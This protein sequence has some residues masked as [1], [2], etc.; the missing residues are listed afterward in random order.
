MPHIHTRPGQHDHTVTGYIV[1]TD[2]SEP[3]ALLHMHKKFDIL[4][5][6]GGHIELDENPWQAIC[7]EL[8][9]ESGY[10]ISQLRILQPPGMLQKLSGATIHPYPL[11]LNTHA[12]TPEHFHSDTAFG[13]IASKSPV[14]A[15]EDSESSDIR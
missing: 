1:R 2:G 9:E 7:H 6:V 13:F 11:V 5:P 12:I 15:I 8:L 14:H 3:R 4:L 10:D